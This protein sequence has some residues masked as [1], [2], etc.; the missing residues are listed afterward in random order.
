VKSWSLGD[1]MYIDTL[2]GH[3]GHIIALDCDHRERPI[4]VSRDHTCRMWKVKY[5][6]IIIASAYFG[7]GDGSQFEGDLLNSSRR[8]DDGA[9]CVPA[10]FSAA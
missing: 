3:Q 6:Q 4:T 2:Y 1:M 8:G 10:C 9:C 5:N 7:P